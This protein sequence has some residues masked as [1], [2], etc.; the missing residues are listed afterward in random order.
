MKTQTSHQRVYKALQTLHRCNAT[1][2]MRLS[3]LPLQAWNRRLKRRKY[4]TGGLALPIVHISL[5]IL[6]VH[7]DNK[8]SRAVSVI[9]R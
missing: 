8:H 4:L 3:S 9:F 2:Q 6:I 1:Q 7:S 5:A